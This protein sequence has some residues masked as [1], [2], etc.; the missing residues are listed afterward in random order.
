MKLK[1]YSK[2]SLK[3]KIKFVTQCAG[4]SVLYYVL[5]PLFVLRRR[6]K[7]QKETGIS[8]LTGKDGADFEGKETS[9]KYQQNS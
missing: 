2:S 7:K 3:L 9:E 4:K 1:T 6:K 5:L 8:Y